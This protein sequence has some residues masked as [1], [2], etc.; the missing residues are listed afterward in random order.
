MKQLLTIAK[1][2]LFLLLCLNVFIWIIAQGAGHNIPLKTNLIFGIRSIILL[3][4]L[5]LCIYWGRKK[6]IKEEKTMN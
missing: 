3:M 4:L 2:I 1:I 5:L 6:K